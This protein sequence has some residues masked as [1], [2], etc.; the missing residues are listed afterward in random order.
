M[1]LTNEKIEVTHRMMEK[2]NM[3]RGVQYGVPVDPKE[4]SRGL[5]WKGLMEMKDED[6]D[7]IED[8]FLS[9]KLGK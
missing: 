7:K 6:F 4:P 1:Q 9:K 2:N 8:Y 3:T 5:S